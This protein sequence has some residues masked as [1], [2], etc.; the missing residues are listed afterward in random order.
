MTPLWWLLAF[1]VLQRIAE[2]AWASRNTRRLLAE[3]AIE[4]GRSHYP[5]VVGVHV[6][7][8][9]SM[10]VFV[11]PDTPIR[12]I[13]LGVFILLQGCRIW[14]IASLGRYWTTRVIV[15]SEGVLVTRGPYRYLRHPNYLIVTAEIAVLPMAFGAWPIALIFSVLNAAVLTIRIRVEDRALAARRVDTGQ[16]AG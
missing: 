5:L 13:W 9:C 4:H 8:L 1:V 15:P 12:P 10:A 14:I 16:R 2:L 3:G 11:P 6:A 7:W